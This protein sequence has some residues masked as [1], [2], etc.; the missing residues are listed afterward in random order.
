MSQNASWSP[1][2]GVPAPGALNAYV[3]STGTNV[4]VLWSPVREP[5]VTAFS[6]ATMATSITK[7]AETDAGTTSYLD[8]DEVDNANLYGHGIGRRFVIKS[9][10]FCPMAAIQPEPTAGVSNTPPAPTGLTATVDSTGTNVLLAWSPAVGSVT[11]Y[12][13]L[14][15]TYNPSTGNYSYSQIGTTGAG[16]TSLKMS[17][18][19]SGGNDNNNIYEVE[20]DYAGGSFVTADFVFALPAVKRRQ[21][22]T[23]T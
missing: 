4:E 15:G 6:V 13:I 3:D 17:G 7:I 9:W 23:S 18:A 2:D 5:R 8:V 19:F 11:G 1:Y 22:T 12:T 21:P 20:A 14:R 10:P 16:T